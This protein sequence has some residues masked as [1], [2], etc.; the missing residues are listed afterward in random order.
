MD[1][2]GSEV[3]D[4]L[5]PWG[6]TFPSRSAQDLPHG[7]QTSDIE[8]PK[9]PTLGLR[10]SPSS[11]DRWTG[12]RV[13]NGTL[14]SSSGAGRIR[15]RGESWSLISGSSRRPL[16]QNYGYRTCPDPSVQPTPLMSEV[17]SDRGG[18]PGWWGHPWVRLLSNGEVGEPLEHGSETDGD[19][20][21]VK[22]PVA[23]GHGVGSTTRTG[24]GWVVP[25]TG[26]SGVSVGRREWK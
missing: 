26:V 25:R 23:C 16:R 8:R 7:I 10:R 5:Y 15:S 1:R 24:V 4:R 6:P 2:G 11:Q 17:G 14:R 9:R 3:T 22:C 21:G 19:T 20:G 18:V 13:G 12:P